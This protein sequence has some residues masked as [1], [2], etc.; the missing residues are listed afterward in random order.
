MSPGE[1]SRYDIF[2]MNAD[3]TDMRRLTSSPSDD[4]WRGWSPEGRQIVFTS[5]PGRLCLLRGQGLP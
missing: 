4:G 2:V 1:G 5:Q 3:G